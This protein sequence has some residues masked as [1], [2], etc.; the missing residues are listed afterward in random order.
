MTFKQ[1][2]YKGLL[3]SGPKTGE[4]I[5]NQTPIYRVNILEELPTLDQFAPRLP[6]TK[7][8]VYYHHS[9][10]VYNTKEDYRHNM[11]DETVAFGFWIPEDWTLINIMRELMS[12]Y[13]PKERK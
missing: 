7:P 6:T 8:F 13:K 10:E 9:Q 12:N 1:T 2:T 11:I 3:L 5:E 4:W